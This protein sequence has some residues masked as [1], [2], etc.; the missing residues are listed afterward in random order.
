MALACDIIIAVESAK[1]SLPEPRVG[2]AALAG[3]PIRLVRSIGK[4]R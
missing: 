4:R 2:L 1:F 3:G